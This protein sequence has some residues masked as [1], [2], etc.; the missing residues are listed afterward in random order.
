MKVQGAKR[1]P[2]LPFVSCVYSDVVQS[3]AS[4]GR[5]REVEWDV[6]VSKV[7]FGDCRVKRQEMWAATKKELLKCP[8]RSKK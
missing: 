5:R 7:M 1:N 8:K 4:R 3:E 6:G 2:T